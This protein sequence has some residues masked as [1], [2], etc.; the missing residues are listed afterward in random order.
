M[1]ALG[2]LRDIYSEQEARNSRDR[3]RV[4]REEAAMRR[5]QAGDRQREQLF[6][7][8]RKKA[9]I[10]E[11]K[12]WQMV[13][14]MNRFDSLFGNKFASWY[15]M[16]LPDPPRTLK[17]PAWKVCLEVLPRT[18]GGLVRRGIRATLAC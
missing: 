1:L 3:E 10:K 6:K 11:T 14:A 4:G 13:N 5:V 8:M 16:N 15:L 17:V 7:E 2:R 12:R 18:C 9:K